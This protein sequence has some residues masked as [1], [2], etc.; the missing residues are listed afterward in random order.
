MEKEIKAIG[1]LHIPNKNDEEWK[2]FLK[3]NKKKKEINNN[4]W[5]HLP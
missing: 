2:K 5:Y 3:K 4:L 1:M